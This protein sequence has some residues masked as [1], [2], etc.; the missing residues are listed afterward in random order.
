MHT[1]PIQYDCAADVLAFIWIPIAFVFG[2]KTVLRLR[3]E[4]SCAEEDDSQDCDR[5]LGDSQYTCPR[6]SY[7]ILV[8]IM[9]LEII[10]PVYIGLAGM[11]NTFV[12]IKMSSLSAR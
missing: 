5:I 8:A 1:W 6:I 9:D 2:V 4:A 11:R 7:S 10:I 12:Y 3:D